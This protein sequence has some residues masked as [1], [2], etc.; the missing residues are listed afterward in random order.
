MNSTQTALIQMCDEWYQ[1]VDNGKLTGVVFLD[2]RKAIGSLVHK[3]LLHKMKTQFGLT[4]SEPG[5]FESHLTNREQICNNKW[6]F[7]F[8]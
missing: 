3:I 2:I 4:N 7:F 8:F 1:N 6:E 5:W